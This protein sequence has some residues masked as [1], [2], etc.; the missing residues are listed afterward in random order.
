MKKNQKVYL[1]NN[2][3]YIPCMM[4]ESIPKGI[5]YPLV[6]IDK[7]SLDKKI[8]DSF[9]FFSFLKKIDYLNTRFFSCPSCPVVPSP[10]F[11]E[12]YPSFLGQRDKWDNNIPQKTI[13]MI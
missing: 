13:I 6:Y 7:G 3:K 11:E 1:Q 12:L 10:Q 9:L 5:I 4:R 8:F 2:Q